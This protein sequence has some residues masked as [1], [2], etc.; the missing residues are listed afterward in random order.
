[1][2]TLTKNSVSS[3]LSAA[4]FVFLLNGSINDTTF[5]DGASCFDATTP[6]AFHCGT[7]YTSF[8][9]DGTGWQMGG[10]LE[11]KQIWLRIGIRF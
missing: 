2:F 9:A 10:S 3:V 1:M 5:I 4:A 11:A 6:Y 7:I 8:A